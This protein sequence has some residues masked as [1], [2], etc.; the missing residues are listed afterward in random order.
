MSSSTGRKLAAEAF[1]TFFLVFMGCGA[2]VVDGATGRLGHL[3]VS[4]AWGLSVL[5]LIHAIGEVS[6]AHINPAVTVAFAAA[7]RF[8]ARS[9]APYAGAQVAGAVA[10][11]LVLRYLFPADP[12]LGATQ[13]S[14]WTGRAFVFEFL[15]SY[16]L[17]F[18]V[19]AVSSGSREQG[20]MAG[21][22]VGA[23]VAL[24][25]LVGGRVTGASMNPARTL[26]PALVS[27]L[28]AHLWLYVLAPTLGA[29]AG[30]L[31]YQYAKGERW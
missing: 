23:V 15:M 14:S 2:I 12:T 7:R 28:T 24:D 20:M 6:G 11:A 3:G 16:L 31:S 25:A 1:G 17:M 22:A 9:V 8:P 10:A 27:G 30:A 18:V 29:V 13:I 21:V 26:G 4:L 5:V 19:M